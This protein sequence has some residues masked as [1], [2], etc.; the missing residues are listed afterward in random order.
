MSSFAVMLRAIAGAFDATCAS[1]RA[2]TALALA[3]VLVLAAGGERAAAALDSD[4]VA[5]SVAEGDAG[6][7]PRAAGAYS[8]RPRLDPSAPDL[9]RVAVAR[10]R[11]RWTDLREGGRPAARAPDGCA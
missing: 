3:V 2:R 11:P 4:T 1:A 6:A 5:G 10:L 7:R 9:R 8:S